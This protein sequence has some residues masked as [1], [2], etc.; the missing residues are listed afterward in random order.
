MM[1]SVIR[2]MTSNNASFRFEGGVVEKSG[3]RPLA[4]FCSYSQ[5]M[6]D[7]KIC[8]APRG[9]ASDT[10]RFFEGLRAGCLVVCEH[11]TDEWFYVGAPVLFVLPT[12]AN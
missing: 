11:L 6:M 12:G 8:L 5:R 4:E 3:S 10:W 1:L 7:S 9:T 2:E